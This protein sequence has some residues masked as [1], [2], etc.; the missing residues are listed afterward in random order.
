MNSK[1]RRAAGA[2]TAGAARRASARAQGR[3]PEELAITELR[4]REVIE[5]IALSAAAIRARY[6]A[7]TDE[8][9]DPPTIQLT[10]IRPP[11]RRPPRESRTRLPAGADMAAL[12]RP[13]RPRATRHHNPAAPLRRGFFCAQNP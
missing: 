13:H 4:R 3:R 6:E 9:V 2:R 12:A 8:F 5:R 1:W 11:E 7:D 10:A